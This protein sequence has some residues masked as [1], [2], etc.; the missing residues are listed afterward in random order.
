MFLAACE[1]EG[2]CLTLSMA[3][4]STIEEIGIAAPE[5]IRWFQVFVLHDREMTCRMVERAQHAG[6]TALVL[7][8][9]CAVHGKRYHDM[10]NQFALPPH[11]KSVLF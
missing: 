1:S 2:T 5:S 10:R 7:T 4:T 3:A 11:L 8:V 6:F 9:D